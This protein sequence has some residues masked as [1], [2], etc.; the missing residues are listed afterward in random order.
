MF[1]RR[2]K[3]LPPANP[4]WLRAALVVADVTAFLVLA[5]GSR[6]SYAGTAIW[7]SLGLFVLTLLLWDR[8]RVHRLY[9]V[10]LLAQ[11]TTV[12]ALGVPIYRMLIHEA[13]P[14]RALA[15]EGQMLFL[16]GA[17]WLVALAVWLSRRGTGSQGTM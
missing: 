16:A 15:D 3:D 7:L 17:L 2:P 8:S 6:A 13:V 14:G 11:T 9:R 12:I 10:L 5:L 4:S 1:M